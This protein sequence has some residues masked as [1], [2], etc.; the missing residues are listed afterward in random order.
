MFYH[1]KRS[2]DIL[3]KLAVKHDI[4]LSHWANW[5][6]ESGDLSMFTAVV[7]PSNKGYSF[8]IEKMAEACAR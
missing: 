6:R 3:K 2:N 8:L 1:I 7:H 4:Q 5:Y